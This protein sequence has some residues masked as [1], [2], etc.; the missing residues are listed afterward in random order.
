MIFDLHIDI[1]TVA[2]TIHTQFLHSRFQVKCF[3]SKKDHSSPLQFLYQNVLLPFVSTPLAFLDHHHPHHTA[4]APSLVVLLNRVTLWFLLVPFASLL[5]LFCVCGAI[6]ITCVGFPLAVLCQVH[7]LPDPARSRRVAVPRAWRRHLW[8]RSESIIKSL[9]F[10]DSFRSCRAHDLLAVAFVMMKIYAETKSEEDRSG[11]KKLDSAGRAP[12]AAAAA[13]APSPSQGTAPAELPLAS[14]EN[15]ARPPPSSSKPA[16]SPGSASSRPAPRRPARRSVRRRVTCSAAS[17]DRIE[18][19][20]QSDLTTVADIGQRIVFEPLLPNSDDESQLSLSAAERETLTCI[21][22]SR[23]RFPKRVKDALSKQH[24]ARVAQLRAVIEALLL[25][26]GVEPNPG[27][28]PKKKSEPSAAALAILQHRPNVDETRIISPEDRLANTKAL[29]FL[30]AHGRDLKPGSILHAV[31]KDHHATPPTEYECSINIKEKLEAM[32]SYT[33]DKIDG[34]GATK[35]GKSACPVFDVTINETSGGRRTLSQVFPVLT[36]FPPAPADNEADNQ[37]TIA[38]IQR[39]ELHASSNQ[40]KWNDETDAVNSTVYGDRLKRLLADTSIRTLRVLD[41]DRQKVQF[42]ALVRGTISSYEGID[43]NNNLSLKQ[44]IDAKEPVIA[45]LLGLVRK[46]L[47]VLS[48]LARQRLRNQHLSLQLSGRVIRQVTAQVPSRPEESSETLFDER[49]IKIAKRQAQE[50]NLGRAGNTLMATKGRTTSKYDLALNSANDDQKQARVAKARAELVANIEK[51]HPDKANPALTFA[52]GSNFDPIRD[53]DFPANFEVTPAELIN[54]L[55]GACTGAAPGISGWTEE[56]LFDA[57]SRDSVVAQNLALIIR[58]IALCHITENLVPSLTACSL[59]TLDKEGG[60]IRPIALCE[61]F[62]KIASRIVLERESA[63]LRIAL[64]NQFG[65]AYSNGTDKIIHETRSFV[66]EVVHNGDGAVLTIDFSN[67]FNAPNRQGMWEKV[68]DFKLLRRIFALEYSSP[69]TLFNRQ[70]EQNFLSRAGCRQGTTAG[71]VL[72]CLTIQDMLNDLN[73]LSGVRALAYMDDITILAQNVTAAGKAMEVVQR[74][75]KRLDLAINMKKCELLTETAPC[76]LPESLCQLSPIR[77]LKRLLGA[78]IGVDENTERAFL[79][80]RVKDTH[81]AFFRRLACCY[82]PWASALLA[83]CGVPKINHLLRTHAPEVTADIAKR[84]DEDTESVVRNWLNLD[85]EKMSAQDMNVH[86]AFLHLP[87]SLGGMGFTRSAH[88]AAAA[89][90][91][92]S[93]TPTLVNDKHLRM[94]QKAF[95]EPVHNR[96]AKYIDDISALHKRHRTI[97]SEKGTAAMFRDPKF[98]A[99]RS[100][101]RMQMLWRT[102]GRIQGIDDF[103][104]S[105]PGCKHAHADYLA[106]MFHVGTCPLVSGH[107]ATAAH[108]AMT[109]AINQWCHQ[110]GLVVDSSEPR[111]LSHV[112]CPG[113]KAQMLPEKWSEHKDSCDN[114]HTATPDPRITGPDGRVWNVRTQ[115]DAAHDAIVF[116][117]S[118]VGARQASNAAKPQKDLFKEREAKKQSLYAELAAKHNQELVTLASTEDGCFNKQGRLFIDTLAAAAN[119]N[120]HELRHYL[121][122][123]QQEAHGAS[124]ANALSRGKFNKYVHEFAGETIADRARRVHD[125]VNGRHSVNLEVISTHVGANADGAAP[126]T[127]ASASRSGPFPETIH[128]HHRRRTREEEPPGPQEAANPPVSTTELSPTRLNYGPIF[129]DSQSPIPASSRSF[130]GGDIDVIIARINLVVGRKDVVELDVFDYA[131]RA[132]ECIK[133]WIINNNNTHDK[134]LS[135]DEI[136]QMAY[137]KAGVPEPVAKTAKF[138]AEVRILLW[139]YQATDFKT[140]RIIAHPPGSNRHGGAVNPQLAQN[141]KTFSSERGP[142]TTVKAGDANAAQVATKVSEN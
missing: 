35:R 91:A 23:P 103:G 13:A 8:R 94:S 30:T 73:K 82:G 93:T 66:R 67:A 81:E 125:I 31:I 48:G 52:T 41:T 123:R 76:D 74:H 24:K 87:T 80:E 11:K 51:L 20:F 1:I 90:Q 39:S 62:T 45:D 110:S 7:L 34:R 37:F 4:T 89:Y 71:P 142:T 65:V 55:K 68:R 18:K 104:L 43:R 69:S 59:V 63:A 129:K 120:A 101:W 115:Q 92:S 78:T 32:F 42:A 119:A 140:G 86:R 141:Y 22:E 100:A 139:H 108:Y 116:D 105:C 21:V 106:F 114:C 118:Q 29:E 97:N 136:G 128:A 77:C 47:R 75:G 122:E 107:N 15:P 33:T 133:F 19:Q 124:I 16:P 9:A 61:T 132:A 58:D 60:G 83:S 117:Y 2:K 98:K 84:F 137:E 102:C 26:G 57:A 88:V 54:T 130:Y 99:N 5:G 121:Q 14:V 17:L 64:P 113:C 36:R 27:M 40:I 49:Q 111:D 72:F 53:Q 38:Q 135:S 95:S 28:P 127:T 25:I 3:L 85:A 6:G 56:L 12:H 138:V 134:Y 96:I 10:D 112:I 126:T 109:K 50:G 79:N 44:K 70:L 131:L 46:H